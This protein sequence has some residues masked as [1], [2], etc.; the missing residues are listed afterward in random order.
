MR[1]ERKRLLGA[2]HSAR[3]PH[4]MSC[5]VLMWLH[6]EPHALKEVDQ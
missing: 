2:S 6:Y 1:A 4:P 3:H 5:D